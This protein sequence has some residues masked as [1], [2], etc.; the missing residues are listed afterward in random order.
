MRTGVVAE[1]GEIHL[2]NPQ[3]DAGILGNVIPDNWIA[4]GLEDGLNE[5]FSA[6]GLV[7]TQVELAEG[8][9]RVTT[10]DMT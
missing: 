4:G 5:Y 3:T 10:E 8:E 9:A 1:D 6:N 2:T 7:V